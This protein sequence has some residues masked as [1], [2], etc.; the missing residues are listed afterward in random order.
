M[1]SD[2][3]GMVAHSASISSRKRIKI[4]L[5]RIF[6][7]QLSA[8]YQYS[9]TYTRRWA[10]RV[11]A[12]VAPLLKKIRRDP[13]LVWVRETSFDR[14]QDPQTVSKRSSASP[15]PVLCSLFLVV[16]NPQFAWF[17]ETINSVQCQS[18]QEWEL[19]LCPANDQE[20]TLTACTQAQAQDA[21]IHV[22]PVINPPDRGATLDYALS[23]SSGKYLGLLSQHDQLA[24]DACARA[25]A[26]LQ[27][28]EC[29]LLYSDEDC[30]DAQGRRGAP[31]FKPDWSPDLCLS[32][33]Y[34]C[35]FGVYRRSLVETVGGFQN[36]SGGSVEDGC[37]EYDLLLRCAER[38]QRVGHIAHVLYHR[39]SVPEKSARS[40]P[41]TTENLQHV[42]AKVVLERALQRRGETAAVVDGPELFTFHVRRNIA[43]SPLISIIIPTRDQVGVLRPCI[44]SIEA[45]STYTHYEII[46][47]DNGSRDPETLSYLAELPHHVMRDA[48]PF[49]FSRLC[50]RA[51]AQADGQHLLFL[52]N[53]VEIITP[54]W[55]E[56][57][58]E[59]AQRAEVGAVGAQLLYPDQTLQHA[60]VVLG[61]RDIASHAHKYQL[62][63]QLGYQAFPHLVRN[64]SAVTAACMM[65]RKEVYEEVGGMREELAVT[66]NDVD[67]CL[68]LQQQGYTIVYTP[69][70]K[71]YHYESK[72]RWF[73]PP[74]AREADYMRGCWGAA[75]T[76]DPF[77]NPHL[78]L[79]R[80]DFSFDLDRARAWIERAQEKGPQ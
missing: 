42:G 10:S 60:G 51:A 33:L 41:A 18:F 30:L 8:V 61:V 16:E 5:E 1:P 45:K 4:R 57:L 21:R 28:H 29:D 43:D 62:L 49:N 69:Y 54:G 39:R 24:P 48:A 38:S 11:V 65:V 47:I 80:E 36:G 26:Y 25:V 59:Q 17:E 78:T 22:S 63:S 44:A 6:G 34:A 74:R 23:Q 37:V 14:F 35:R 70:A 72:S 68:R 73:Q 67:L 40:N 32:S 3:R 77:Y 55:L 56:A 13:Y 75:I 27:T 2:E 71:L 12:Y 53:D 20:G 50:N 7:W 79:D 66:F 46:I 76:N 64:Y 19:W 52:N 9:R 58:L 15:P 31:F